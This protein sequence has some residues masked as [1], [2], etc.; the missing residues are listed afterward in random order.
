MID[1]QNEHLISF[2]Q[3]AKQLPGRNGKRTHVSTLHR[4]A[5]KGIRGNRL[6]AVRVGGRWLTSSEAVQ[7]FANKLTE[8]MIA[9]AIIIPP[10]LP[11]PSLASKT[12]TNTKALTAAQ[13][14][15]K[16]GI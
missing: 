9:P 10:A 1:L 11:G 14:L 7:R 5:Q 3:A 4:W 6:E 12:S 13:E 8:D 2:A 16:I 15:D